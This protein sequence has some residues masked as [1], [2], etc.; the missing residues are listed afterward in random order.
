MHLELTYTEVKARFLFVKVHTKQS[1]KW[2]L[3]S[4]VQKLYPRAQSH[5]AWLMLVAAKT[6]SVWSGT[7]LSTIQPL[8]CLVKPYAVD[9]AVFPHLIRVRISE[10]GNSSHMHS[11]CTSIWISTAL[12]ISSGRQMPELP[13]QIL[14]LQKQLREVVHVHNYS[15]LLPHLWTGMGIMWLGWTKEGKYTLKNLSKYLSDQEDHANSKGVSKWT[16]FSSRYC[17][18]QCSYWRLLCELVRTNAKL[19]SSCF[20]KAPV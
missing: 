1:S 4:A 11:K 3:V 19:K 10:T 17:M 6:S 18:Q 13:E 14:V 5:L 20:Y 7:T 12:Q 8:R 2:V 9:C 16:A 15:I